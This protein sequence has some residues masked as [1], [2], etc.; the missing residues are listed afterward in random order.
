M[1]PPLPVSGP[2]RSSA[3]VNEDI[4]ALLVASWGRPFTDEERAAYGLLLE[5]WATAVQAEVV[6]AA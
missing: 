2:V 1:P 4:R 5:E 6:K 3:A